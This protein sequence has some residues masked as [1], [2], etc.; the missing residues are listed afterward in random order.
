MHGTDIGSG[1]A[2]RLAGLFPQRVIG[3][4]LAVDRAVL[5]VGATR[6]E[7]AARVRL[8][9]RTRATARPPTR[10]EPTGASAV[11]S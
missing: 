4:H 10:P 6:A 11:P 5:G 7:H 3:T 1:L 2:S 8:T 9:N